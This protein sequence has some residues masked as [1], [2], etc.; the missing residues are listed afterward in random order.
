MENGFVTV[1][2]DELTPCL[3][4]IQTGEIVKT[5][6]LRIR[7]KSELKKFHSKNGWYVNWSKFD[8]KVEVYALRVAGEEEIQGLV[9]L[10]D[11]KDSDATYI[12]WMCA[13]PHNNKYKYGEQ[14]Y[15][16]VGGH[17]FSIAIEKSYEWGHEGFITGIAADEE[18]LKHYVEDL[19]ATY[20]GMIHKFQFCIDEK[21]ARKIK[22][23]YDYEWT[24]QEL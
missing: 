13:A 9:A 1:Y 4:N 23:V 16:G 2:V 20:V 5:E 10:Y 8:A 11:D 18:L 12:Q 24:D 3:K 15:S 19:G 22:E 6:V 17:L 7:S 21:S 14:K